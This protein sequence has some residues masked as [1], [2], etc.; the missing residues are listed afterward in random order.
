MS[1][2][3]PRFLL[4]IFDTTGIMLDFLKTSENFWFSDIFRGCRKRPMP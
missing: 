3:F 4:N 1:Y 2:K